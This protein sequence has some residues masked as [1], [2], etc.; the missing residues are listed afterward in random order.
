MRPGGQRRAVP[1]VPL[2]LM[3]ALLYR[4]FQSLQRRRRRVRLSVAG[5]HLGFRQTDERMT[6]CVV[7]QNRV[8]EVRVQVDLVGWS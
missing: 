3:L 1:P 8:L 6:N 2:K 5:L 4:A 7:R